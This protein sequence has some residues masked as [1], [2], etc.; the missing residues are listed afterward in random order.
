[1]QQTDHNFSFMVI[2]V[3]TLPDTLTPELEKCLEHKVRNVPEDKKE[4]E[5]LH[6]R[7]HEPQFTRICCIGTIYCDSKGNVYEKVFFSRTDECQIVTEFFNYI[8]QFKGKFVHYNGLDF[9][10]PLLLYKALQHNVQPPQRF[11]NLTRFRTDPHYDIMQVLA[12]WGRFK[13]SLSEAL[14]SLGL[15]NSKEELHG[16]DTLTFMQQATD[17]EIQTYNL[18]DCRSEFDLFKRVY[19]VYQ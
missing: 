8:S 5:K 11:C 9:D 10:V 2:D 17:E 7:F 1:M 4:T 18:E 14:Y 15:K 19:E 3:E 16:K 13:I 6:Y 12:A